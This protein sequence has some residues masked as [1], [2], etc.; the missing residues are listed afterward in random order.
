MLYHEP[1][2][3]LRSTEAA[4][5]SAQS[6][7]QLLNYIC[8]DWSAMLH[9]DLHAPLIARAAILHV[10]FMWCLT[11]TNEIR[12]DDLASQ[13][14]PSGLRCAAM[15]VSCTACNMITVRHTNL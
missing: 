12:I 9:A 15:T 13:C 11:G 4:I 2:T 5:L 1:S 8:F 3:A 6:E 7:L 10:S 14:T